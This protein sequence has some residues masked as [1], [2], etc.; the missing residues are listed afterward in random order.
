MK[1]AASSILSW[2]AAALL[3]LTLL[4]SFSPARVRARLT[5]PGNA[6]FDFDPGYRAFLEELAAATPPTA[7]IA[8][9]IPREPDSYLYRAVYRLAPRRVV[10]GESADGA[11]FVA[12]YSRRGLAP[13]SGARAIPGGFLQRR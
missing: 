12:V 10:G 8:L 3:V 13:P 1:R 5:P 9:S 11:Q 4:P 2:T 7:T 6:G